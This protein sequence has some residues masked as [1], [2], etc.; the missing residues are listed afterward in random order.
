MKVP[1][2]LTV[3]GR[4]YAIEVEAHRTLLDVL[5]E[6]MGLIGTN[7]GC[8]HGDC[9]A[10]TVIMDGI[11]INSCLVLA[12]EA[13]GC[14]ITTIEGLAKGGVLHPVQQ[15]FIDEGA[16]QCGFCTPGM[17]MQTVAF[18]GEN[19]DPTVD[20]ARR[21]IEG[22]ICR[23]TGYTKIV[24]AIMAAAKKMKRTSAKVA[25]SGKGKQA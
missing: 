2:N 21:T 25:K 4:G 20:E 11:S 10:C 3:N 22:N 18:L 1:I 17:V 19:P 7:L 6:D 12:P 5:R 9:G 8:G 16:I 15:A 23:C 13:D 24:D 14:E